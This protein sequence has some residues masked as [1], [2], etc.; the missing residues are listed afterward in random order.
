[1]MRKM[2]TLTSKFAIVDPTKK[3]EEMWVWFLSFF[4]FW[5][6]PE[7]G[8]I[9]DVFVKSVVRAQRSRRLL[10]MAFTVRKFNS[11]N[12]GP[13]RE[14]A[15]KVWNKTAVEQTNILSWIMRI[16]AQRIDNRSPKK[17]R[18]RRNEII[19]WIWKYNALHLPLWW[20]AP[21]L[22]HAES[23]VNLVCV[24]FE[25]W[26]H[27]PAVRRDHDWYHSPH[28]KCPGNTSCSLP[29]P[30]CYFESHWSSYPYHINHNLCTQTQLGTHLL[31]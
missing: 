7:V 29:P 28:E 26:S 25:T 12:P 30:R 24:I 11:S 3:L 2:K 13:W 14:A 27:A 5:I 8:R 19:R 15:W 10:E 16:F 1:M 22:Y 6:L 31:H 18:R 20:L 23:L 9:R 21:E 4:I 17:S